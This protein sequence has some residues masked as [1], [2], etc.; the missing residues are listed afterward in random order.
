MVLRSF[1]GL[2]ISSFSRTAEQ[3]SECPASRP[4]HFV[5]MENFRHTFKG[6]SMPILDSSPMPA[7]ALARVTAS[8]DRPDHRSEQSPHVSRQSPPRRSNSP[9]TSPVS[10]ADQRNQSHPH[11]DAPMALVPPRQF[12]YAILVNGGRFTETEQIFALCNSAA[13]AE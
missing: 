7:T 10:L 4:R 6:V 1:P 12:V 13:P 2:T 9:R 8:P 11:Q 3:G 5:Q